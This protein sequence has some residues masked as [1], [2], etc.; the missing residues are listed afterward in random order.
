MPALALS[1]AATITSENGETVPGAAGSIVAGHERS[2][3]LRLERR[4]RHLRHG[5][6]HVRSRLLRSDRLCRDAPTAAPMVGFPGVG[7]GHR[8]LP[9]PP[10]VYHG[11]PQ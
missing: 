8:V 2:I 5:A 11:D 3:L 9:C 1:G 4:G 7:T 10:A 6:V